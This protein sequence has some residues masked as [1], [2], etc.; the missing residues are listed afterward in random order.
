MVTVHRHIMFHHTTDEWS[1]MPRA[2]EV[3]RHEMQRGTHS[4]G[5]NRAN[6]MEGKTLGRENR[7]PVIVAASHTHIMMVE[8]PIIRRDPWGRFLPVKQ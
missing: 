3:L 5:I 8:N 2:L 7:T 1:G 6:I 4:T